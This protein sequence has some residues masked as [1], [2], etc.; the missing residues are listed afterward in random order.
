MKHVSTL[1]VVALLMSAC[2]SHADPACVGT[3]GVCMAGCAT[4]LMAERCMQR[5]M[6]Q[7]DRCMVLNHSRQVDE[8]PVIA[9]MPQRNGIA[10]ERPNTAAQTRSS[11][12]RY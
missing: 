7:R 1:A 12:R 4:E 6:A 8:Q 11:Q 10:I 2:A 3:Y 9:E 5:C